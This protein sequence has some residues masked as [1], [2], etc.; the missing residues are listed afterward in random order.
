MRT[1][2]QELEQTHKTNLAAQSKVR[3]DVELGAFDD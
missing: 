2:L 1:T 3:G